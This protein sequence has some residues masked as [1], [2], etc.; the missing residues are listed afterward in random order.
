MEC[1]HLPIR[2]TFDG[3]WLELFLEPAAELEEMKLSRSAEGRRFYHMEGSG[4]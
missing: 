2:A 1:A 3:V 4:L